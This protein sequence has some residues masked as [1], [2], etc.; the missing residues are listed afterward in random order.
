MLH[1]IKLDA[2]HNYVGNFWDFLNP[3]SLLG[4]VATLV[5]FTLDGALFLALKTTGDIRAGRQPRRPRDRGARRAGRRRVP[6]LDRVQLP[7]PRPHRH[8]V[9]SV[10]LAAVAAVALLVAC[11]A[12]LAGREGVAFGAAAAA[13][14]AATGALFTALYP[15]VLP[16]SI[17]AAYN[18]TVSNASSTAKTLALMTV[19][20]CIF[21]PFV[22]LYQGWTYWVFRKRISAPPQDP[23]QA[24]SRSNPRR[25]AGEATRPPA[26]PARP[27]GQRFIAAVSTLGV[28]TAGLVIV[29]AQLLADGDH[30]G[31]PAR[32]HDPGAAA[33]PGRAGRGG[34]RP[35][36]RGLGHR[37]HVLSRERDG[38]GRTARPPAHPG[39]PARAALAGRAAERGA[40]RAGHR[41]DR[42]ARRLLRQ[43]PAAAR[44]GQR[45]ADRGPGPGRGG[46]PARRADDR[47]DPAAHP[48]L[49]RAGREGHRARAR[50][51]AGARWRCSRTISSTWCPGCRRSR[52]S[53]GPRR[54]ARS[55][56]RSPATTGAP[57]WGRCGSRSCPPWCSSSS[58]PCR[59]RWWRSG[60]VSAWSTA[61]S[62]C[63]PA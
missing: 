59:S 4:G 37:G 16:S 30:R 11:A 18:L 12:N 40:D 24:P 44:A 31:V 29:Q 47:R 1:G 61:T 63:A 51:S 57:P 15:N 32:R 54:S 58:R 53:A 60:S 13:I 10:V 48:A 42:G 43:V 5:L 23:P 25:L 56:A 50:S 36:R 34:G 35:G 6:G 41:R 27:D 39:R 14:G 26:A 17:N 2:A 28:L 22:L 33:G 49:R 55:S 3:Y 52:C 9:A 7:G 38:Q 19:I 20:A 8:G 46:R 21:L 62:T 45:R